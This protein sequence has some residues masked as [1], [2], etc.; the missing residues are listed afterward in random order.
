V[1][2]VLHRP[3]TRRWVG[4]QVLTHPGTAEVQR[5]LG[6]TPGFGAYDPA[7]AL[8]STFNGQLS[9]TDGSPSEQA[10][11]ISR[12]QSR[13]R[14]TSRSPGRAQVQ[15]DLDILAELAALRAEVQRLTIE[16]AALKEKILPDYEELE[17]LDY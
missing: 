12:T 11:V 15:A 9:L 6:A 1:P 17:D 5:L 4:T 7:A 3:S 14:R 8:C 2:S 13:S 16:N 10:L